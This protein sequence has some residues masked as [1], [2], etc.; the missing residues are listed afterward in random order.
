MSAHVHSVTIR[1]V[2]IADLLGVSKQRANQIADGRSFPTPVGRT[3]EAGSGIG[4]VERWA[5][6]W[7]KATPWR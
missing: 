5:K 7:R 4:E 2:D 6:R 1:L 3:D